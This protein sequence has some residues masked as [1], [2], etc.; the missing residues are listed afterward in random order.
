MPSALDRDG[1]RV[2]RKAGIYLN[3]V[4]VGMNNHN[5]NLLEQLADKGD[6]VCNYVDDA[7]KC[8]ALVATTSPARSST[9]A[10]DV[11]IKSSS[12]RRRSSATACS[13]TRTARSPTPTSA[14]TRS[15]PGE[16]G[17]RATKSDPRCTRSCGLARI[18]VTGL[19]ALC[20]C[21]GR[22]ARAERRQKFESDVA[23]EIA[24]PVYSKNAAGSF[25][26]DQ[27]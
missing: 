3:T 26:F 16:V 6:G 12:I 19:F 21:A 11:K 27:R 17:A 5:D 23:T 10:R 4:G 18:E 1:Q 2:Q 7:R 8:A 20:M 13:A 24:Q 25:S 9:I 22:A 15:T 14:T